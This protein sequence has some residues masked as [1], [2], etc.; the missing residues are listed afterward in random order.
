[1]SILNIGRPAAARA[2]LIRLTISLSAAPAEGQR[3]LNAPPSLPWGYAGIP[4]VHARSM[5][6]Q[7]RA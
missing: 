4:T 2:R 7:V 6:A 5:Q 3:L 1:M